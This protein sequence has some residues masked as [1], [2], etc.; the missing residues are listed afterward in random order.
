MH[1]LFFYM[2]ENVILMIEIARSLLNIFHAT[3]EERFILEKPF[4]VSQ[5]ELAQHSWFNKKKRFPVLCIEIWIFIELHFFI[6]IE[7]FGGNRFPFWSKSAIV[8]VKGISCNISLL[9]FFPPLGEGHLVPQS[10]E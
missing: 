5:G 9:W 3:N 1:V 7:R 10:A 8:N 4:L 6:A 2:F